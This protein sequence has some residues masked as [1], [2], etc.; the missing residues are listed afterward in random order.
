MYKKRWANVVEKFGKVNDID[1]VS[2]EA[3]VIENI[4]K[5]DW[6]NKNNFN[7]NYNDTIY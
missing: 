5:E 7:D 4:L 2:F 1:W 3:V 6:T